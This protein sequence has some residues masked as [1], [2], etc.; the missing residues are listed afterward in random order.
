MQPAALRPK[1]RRKA[2]AVAVLIIILSLG[3]AG[4]VLYTQYMAAQ[5]PEPS[6]TRETAAPKPAPQELLRSAAA[7]GTDLG[8]LDTAM[9]ELEGD[10]ND[11]QGDLSE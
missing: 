8:E 7:A 11:K 3:A 2:V 1:G 6:Q 4:V 9:G 10:M 5:A